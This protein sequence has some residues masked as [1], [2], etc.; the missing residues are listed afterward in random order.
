MQDPVPAR[1]R[2][3]NN[4]TSCPNSVS[5]SLRTIFA[6]HHSSPLPAP[7]PPPLRLVICSSL[8]PSVSLYFPPLHS[9]SLSLLTLFTFSHSILP[10]PSLPP[11]IC[12]SVPPTICVSVLSP[13]PHSLLCSPAFYLVASA[14]RPLTASLVPSLPTHHVNYVTRKLRVRDDGRVACA[15]CVRVVLAC[16]GTPAYPAYPA[17]IPSTRGYV[18]HCVASTPAPPHVVPH[19]AQRHDAAATMIALIDSLNTLKPHFSCR[20]NHSP[21]TTH[22]ER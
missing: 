22:R 5:L 9:P 7:P 19:Q 4:I 17:R 2:S 21:K 14:S 10:R 6:Y 15:H 1:N 16:W 18:P 13:F 12:L 8:P 3:F 20:S 11:S